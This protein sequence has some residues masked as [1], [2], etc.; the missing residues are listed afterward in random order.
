VPTDPVAAISD[1]TGGARAFHIVGVGGGNM[2]TIASVLAAMGHRVS[3]SDEKP[4]PV[5]ERLERQGVRIFVGHDPA[6][7]GRVDAVAF[8]TAVKDDNVELVE[9][10]RRGIPTLSRAD[11][12]AAICRTR[13]TLAVSGTHGKTTTTAM[14]AAILV[15]TGTDPSFMVGGE[16]PGGRGGAH[17]GQGPWL[18]VE[19]DE[20]DGAFLR[21]PAEGVI[22]TSVEA[23]HLDHY[24]DMAAL[25]AAFA[26]FVAQAPG[27]RVVC[28]DDAGAARLAPAGAASAP[29]LGPPGAASAAPGSVVTYGTAEAAHCRA[30]DVELGAS[31]AH[32]EA[33]ADGHDLGRFD[34]ALPGLYNVRNATAA[35]A[36][37]TA[38]G[39]GPDVAR[40]ALANYRSVGRRFELRGTARGVTYIDDY[41]HNPGKVRAVLAAAR[42]GGWGRV[43]AVF[44]PHRYTRTAALWPE[45]AHAFVDADLLVVT[46]IYPAGESPVPGVSGRLVADAVRASS[47][48]LPVEYVEDRPGL[49]ELL[50]G[51]L[52]P[53]DLCLT[54]SA[55]DLN[56]LPD[57]LLAAAE[58][59]PEGGAAPEDRT[60]PED[61]TAERGPQP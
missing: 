25:E 33:I 42:A 58:I 19:A 37:A 61:G 12:L 38:L 53:G 2:N 36:M 59:Q 50:R 60:A 28:L 15:E 43:V 40:T 8:S 11:V 51:R 57:E 31:S 45:F 5:L 35:L 55:G 22:V 26:Q 48:A 32:F 56:T 44:Q 9:A 49:V 30:V 6:H 46:G 14:L 34:I 3:G 1:L 21:L 7:V 54:M 4:S 41:A 18:V 52:R 20:S 24:G 17:W 23:D 29:L 39:I 27:P 10:G 47:P 13:R 16:L